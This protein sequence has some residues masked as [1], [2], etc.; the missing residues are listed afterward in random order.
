MPL[1]SP[2]ATLNDQLEAV[3]PAAHAAGFHVLQGHRFAPT[4]AGHVAVLLGF[5]APAHGDV[6]LDAGSG[7][8][9]VA[10]LMREARPDLSFILLNRCSAQMRHAPGGDGFRSVIS[11]MHALPLAGVSVD[12]VMFTWA[13]CHS[14]H[15]VALAEAA[16]VVKPGGWLFLYELERVTGDNALFEQ[17]LCARAY[18]HAE[19]LAMCEAAGWVAEFYLA[20][21]TDD[22]TMR[23]LFAHDPA[24]HDAIMGELRPVVWKLTQKDTAA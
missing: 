17:H 9:E 7:F 14:D 2:A 5:M 18:R 15:P 3:S 22:A 20:P 21:A 19:M 1:D 24:L 11:D 12:G 13:L 23:S 4:D 10:R 8:G 6:I 16:R